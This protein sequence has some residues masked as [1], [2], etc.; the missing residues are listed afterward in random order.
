MAVRSKKHEHV[1]RYLKHGGNFSLNFSFYRKPAR[2]FSL[3]SCG[4]GPEGGWQPTFCSINQHGRRK[5]K[6]RRVTKKKAL[7]E[8]AHE[9]RPSVPIFLA[10]ELSLVPQV[11]V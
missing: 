10:D 4:S 2:A 3:L 11:T 7:Q 6:Q 1:S 5:T 8:V 9:E